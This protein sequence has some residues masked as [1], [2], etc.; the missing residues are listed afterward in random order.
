MYTYLYGYICIHI[1]LYIYIYTYL[2]L[3]PI[4]TWAVVAV[5]AN[6]TSIVIPMVLF[7]R[8]AL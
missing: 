1:C 2:N 3:Q 6:E 7:A 5:M 8:R 4:N